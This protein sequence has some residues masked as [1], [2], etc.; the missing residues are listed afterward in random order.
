MAGGDHPLIDGMAK[1]GFLRRGVS[2]SVTPRE[3]RLSNLTGL[4]TPGE[5][6]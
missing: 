5:N 2:D 6:L 3:N 4:R 1:A